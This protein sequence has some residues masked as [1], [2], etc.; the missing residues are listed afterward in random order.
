MNNHLGID[1]GKVII[2]AVE[3][4]SADTS[5]LSGTMDE[6][7][8]TPPN[9]AAFETIRDLVDTF[10]G[11]VWIVSKASSSTQAKTRSWLQ[12]WRFFDEVGLSWDKLRFC[13]RREEKA[14]HCRELHVSHFIDDRLDVLNHLRPDVRH[15][16][17]F[18]EQPSDQEIPDWTVQVQDWHDAKF[19]IM[20][21]L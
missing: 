15:L 8:R 14:K 16:Y 12:H 11:N 18:G 5:F 6:A 19:Q 7:M 4:G 13:L 3:S 21:D 2:S 10:D 1:F 17:L 20:Q 9:D